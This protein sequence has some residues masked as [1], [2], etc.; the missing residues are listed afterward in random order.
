MIW[1]S[2]IGSLWLL[3]APAVA[4][5]QVADGGRGALR[6][7]VHVLVAYAV[8][9][10][11]ILVWVWWIARKLSRLNNGHGTPEQGSITESE[12]L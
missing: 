10:I 1:R 5:A 9:W 3:A 4:A 11:L 12:G 7:Y 8:V 6:P 2:S